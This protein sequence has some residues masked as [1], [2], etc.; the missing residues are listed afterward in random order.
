MELQAARVAIL[1]PEARAFK[2]TVLSRLG[3]NHEADEGHE[4]KEERG[5]RIDDRARSSILP[6]Y[7]KE[8][9]VSLSLPFATA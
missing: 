6:L 7:D 3:S 4:G 9:E 5:W 8:R 2:P 1:A